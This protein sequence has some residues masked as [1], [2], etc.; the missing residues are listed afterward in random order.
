MTTT[1]IL[2]VSLTYLA[3]QALNVQSACNLTAVAHGFAR[4]MATLSSLLPEAGTDELNTH[5]I[6]V[7]WADKIAHL[8]GTQSLGDDVVMAAYTA[9]CKLT[10]G[11]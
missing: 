3:Q 1:P 4:A 6:A 9:A 5:P 10:R 7:L 8:T 2:P 11:E